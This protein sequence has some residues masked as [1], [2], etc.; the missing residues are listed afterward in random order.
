MLFAPEGEDNDVTGND[1][2]DT[3]NDVT[4]EARGLGVDGGDAE[5]ETRSVY[6]N[7][8]ADVPW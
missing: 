6:D 4:D 5:P 7:D 3:G 8:D 2:E 1:D